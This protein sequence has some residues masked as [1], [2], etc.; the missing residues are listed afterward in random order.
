MK[1]VWKYQLDVVGRQM[2]QMPIGA[3]IL[4]IGVQ[5][6]YPVIW[7]EVDTEAGIE[8][9]I[10]TIVTTGER[11]EAHTGYV[12]TATIRDWFVAHIFEGA[13]KVDRRKATDLAELRAELKENT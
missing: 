12:G 4:H 8:P 6:E 13:M 9:R 11:Y 7:A 5:N 1:S 10:F 3:K 2:L